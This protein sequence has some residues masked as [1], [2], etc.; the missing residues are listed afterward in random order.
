MPE[1]SRVCSLALLSLIAL[2]EISNA[3]PDKAR[4]KACIDGVG[5]QAVRSCMAGSR[6]MKLI[7]QCRAEAKLVIE[8]CV[9]SK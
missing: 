6:G 8:A 3:A 9:N 4:R 1:I 7:D 5:N 2:T